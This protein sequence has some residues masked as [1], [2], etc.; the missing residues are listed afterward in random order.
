MS[1]EQKRIPLSPIFNITFGDLYPVLSE[2][3]MIFYETAVLA[4]IL[5]DN[6]A[7]PISGEDARELVRSFAETRTIST[8][9]VRPYVM[10]RHP[11]WL[12]HVEQWREQRRQQREIA[13]LARGFEMGLTHGLRA[14]IMVYIAVRHPA[15]NAPEKAAALIDRYLSEHHEVSLEV[16][17]RMVWDGD[18]SWL[19]FV[20]RQ[21]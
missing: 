15:F 11:E 4:R 13:A 12:L 14:K 2:E 10:A 7:D 19:V 20:E 5:H 9:D 21:H 6:E 1:D 18:P 16:L 3:A 8:L 17:A